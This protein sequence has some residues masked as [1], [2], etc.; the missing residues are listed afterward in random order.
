[1]A[2]AKR[3]LKDIQ[4]VEVSLV[5]SPANKQKFLIAKAEDGSLN[6]VIESNG[7]VDGTVLKV[8]GKVVKNVSHVS[9]SHNSP[10]TDYEGNVN[11]SYGVAGKEKDGLVESKYYYLAKGKVMNEQILAELK[12]FVGDEVNVEKMEV[13]AVITEIQKAMEM[14]NKYNSEVDLPDDLKEAIGVLAKHAA[15]QG[16]ED[17][18]VVKEDVKNEKKEEVQKDAPKEEAQVKKEEVQ[19]DAHV[20]ALKEITDAV[21]KMS[22][23]VTVL[24]NRVE[25]VEKSTNGRKSIPGQD[26]E[27]NE[28][29]KFPS[30]TP[31][32]GK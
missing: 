17:V 26:V 12:K 29:T 13:D 24:S 22:E 1:M 31:I 3:K 5:K 7:K 28:G 9:F 11:I 4:P 2:K 21:T 30:L 10:A 20:D 25:V 19:K 18:E 23:A 14:V 16:V 32:T 8:N 15:T 27:K 6:V